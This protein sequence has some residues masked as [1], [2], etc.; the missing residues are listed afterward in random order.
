MKILIIRPMAKEIRLDSYN[1]QELG[2]AKGFL[3]CG[4]DCDILFYSNINK[5]ILIP[6]N[7]KNIKIYYRTGK[8]KFAING[9]F[10]KIDDLLEKYDYLQVNEINQLQSI[11]ILKNYDNSYV[12]HGPYKNKYDSIR[13]KIFDFL[14]DINLKCVLKNKNVNVFCKS[15][16]AEEYISKFN[17]NTKVIGVGLDYSKFKREVSETNLNKFNILYVGKIEKRRN[18]VFMLKVVNK[19]IK[20]D[21]RYNLTII[22]QGEKKYKGKIINLIR[23]LKLQNNVNIIEFV[24]QNDISKYYEQSFVFL[25]PTNYE[26]FGMVLLESVFFGTPVLTTYNGGSSV[27]K[28]G[29]IVKKLKV[30]DWVDCIIALKETNYDRETMNSYI[31][32]N[33]S[34]KNLAQNIIDELKQRRP[35]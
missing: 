31:I 26:I 29:I 33:F 3:D 21:N 17:C 14:N 11:E 20:Y 6:Y 4:H 7:N 9:F 2:L 5:E 1:C 13:H 27:I 10:D 34:W 15:S 28:Q 18:I 24:D 8:I 22:G 35:E 16:L 12:Y 19:L 32:N 25:L 30:K 23:K